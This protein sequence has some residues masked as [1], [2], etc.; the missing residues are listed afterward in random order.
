MGRFW[1]SLKNIQLREIKKGT[2]GGGGE[3]KSSARGK[4][5]LKCIAQDIP[6][7]EK[8]MDRCKSNPKIMSRGKKTS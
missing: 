7:H 8:D 5:G 2:E 6:T 4:R 1:G 3:K